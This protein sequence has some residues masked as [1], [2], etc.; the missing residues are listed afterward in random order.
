MV[1]S[2]SG[3]LPPIPLIVLTGFLGAGKTTLLNKLLREP[4]MADTVVIINEFGE[5]GIDHQLVEQV[6]DTMVLMASG[7]LCCTIRGDLVTTLEDLLRRRD[8][9]RIV[10]FRRVVIETTGLA[11]PAPVLHTVLRH[12]YL[13]LRYALDGV[14]TLVDAVNGVDTIDRHAEA[15]KQVA[16]A[17]RL[18]VTKTDLLAQKPDGETRLSALRAR[19]RSLNPAAPILEPVPDGSLPEG[20]LTGFVAGCGLYD[21]DGKIGDVRR[22]LNAEALDEQNSHHHHHEHDHAHAHTHTHTHKHDVNRHDEHIRAFCLTTDTPISRWRF[23]AF[24]DLLLSAHGPALLR[25]K[26]LVQIAEEPERPVVIQGVQ[27]VLH[28]PRKLAA[29]PDDDHRTR[30]VFIVRDLDESF[31]KRLWSAFNDEPSIDTPDAAALVNN[32]LAIPGR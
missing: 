12:P 14:T 24:L 22:W 28:E 4:E 32:P 7:C 9:G 29:W 10:P 30:I 16:M 5:I 17:D 11:D 21:V 3:P 19:L 31:I 25:V 6:D 27:H 23:D 1:T 2:S 13:G 8:N 15:L 26:G 20:G 18:V